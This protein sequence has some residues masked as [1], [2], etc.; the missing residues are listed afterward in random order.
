MTA[1]PPSPTACTCGARR[2]RRR[3][4]VRSIV[5]PLLVG[6]LLP[7][8][9]QSAS[10]HFGELLDQPAPAAS[11]APSDRSS[12]PRDDPGRL[13]DELVHAFRHARDAAAA[14]GVE[15]VITSGYRTPDRQAELFEQ[16]VE[17]YGSS[18]QARHWVLPPDES[19]HV[20]GIAIDIGPR[21]AAAW[22][23]QHGADYGLCRTYSNEWWHF[24]YRAE[25]AAQQSCPAPQDDP[26]S[27]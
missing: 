7:P 12:P 26:A 19:N 5:V 9:V 2:P 6:A 24:E 11:P 15:L 14:E 8:T 23:T 17:K 21:A 1:P 4:R 13:T 20:R 18:E 10:A 27:P 16:A 22:L 3:R 25:W